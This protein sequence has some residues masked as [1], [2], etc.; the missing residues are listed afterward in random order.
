MGFSLANFVAQLG[1]FAEAY[2]GSIVLG[3]L[4]GP[5]AVGLYRLADR[6]MSTV[7]S[8]ATGSIQWV[9]LPEFS[10]LQDKPAELRTSVLTCIRLSSTITLPALAGLAAVSAPLMAS[11]G[12]QW[13]SAAGVLR[14]LC[15][16]GV[17]AMLTCFT[18]PLLQS[19]AKVRLAAV[20]EWSRTLSGMAV[21]I[22]AGLIVRHGS[23]SAQIMAIATA[24]FLAGALVVTPVFVTVLF[25]LSGIH[26]GELLRS[27]APSAL[28]SVAIVCSVL[29]FHVSGLLSSGKPILL[30]GA[31]LAVGLLTGL[32][33]LL[34]L[35]SHLRLS[36]I[37][38][39]RGIGLGLLTKRFA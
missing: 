3:L 21:L 23:V 2:T 4:F 7:V 25:R 12:P 28:S 10:R 34:F 22:A 17:I 16:L 39:I 1:V 37:G 38:W 35:D 9:S 11:V 18:T 14:V 26:L 8:T 15:A 13:T 5:L 20:L 27:I 29:L 19:V 6:M 30:L 33:V 24:R 32:P 31:E 36:L